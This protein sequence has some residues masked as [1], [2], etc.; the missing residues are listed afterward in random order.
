M[1]FRKEVINHLVLSVKSLRGICFLKSSLSTTSY[2]SIH[3]VEFDPE[4]DGKRGHGQKS[5]NTVL[6]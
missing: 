3:F 4:T 1:P 5:N 2:F 6:F